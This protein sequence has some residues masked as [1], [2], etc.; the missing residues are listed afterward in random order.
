MEDTIIYLMEKMKIEE[1]EVKSSE[2]MRSSI[3]R[4]KMQRARS[5]ETRFT[6]WES[7]I[8]VQKFAQQRRREYV[9][10]ECH[11]RKREVDYRVFFVK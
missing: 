1:S 11:K 8:R 7:S 5:N 2:K 10:A 4:I 9:P 6:N 3:D